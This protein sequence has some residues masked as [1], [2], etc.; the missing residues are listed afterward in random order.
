MS[1]KVYYLKFHAFEPNKFKHLGEKLSFATQLFPGD[2]KYSGFFKKIRFY[3][4]ETIFLIF[5]LF[6]SK[7]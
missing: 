1:Y 6:F 4:F 5:D 7:I 3:F 2:L